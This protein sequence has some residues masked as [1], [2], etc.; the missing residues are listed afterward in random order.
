MKLISA[1]LCGVNCAW[2]GKTKIS[3]KAL[4]LIKSGELIPVC[5]EQLG[6]L[7]TPRT[8]QEIHNGS[9][10]DVLAGRCK[11]I[12]KEGKDVTVQF[13]K[14]AEETLKIAKL[15]GAKEFIAK[16]KSP[17]CGCGLTYDGTFSS[18]LIQGDG[19]TT[20][21]LKQNG[22]KVINSEDI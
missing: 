15:V 18:T 21:L 3:P 14:G 19:V 17:S 6:G 20:A 12:N 16:S 1:C 2:N 5:P 13:I 8:P 22:I 7:G 10:D 9:G 11:V 4:E